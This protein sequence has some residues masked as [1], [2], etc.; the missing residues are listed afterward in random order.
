VPEP[1][2][3]RP[4]VFLDR[5][6]TIAEEVGYLNHLSR[7]RLFP[8]VAAAVCRLNEANL[9]LVVVTNQS[10]V[11]R[12]YFPE[13]L[14][15]AIHDYMTQQL[16]AGGARIDAIYYCPHT[17]TDNCTCRKPKTGML[18]RA[19]QEHAIDLKR[20]FVVGDRYG[21]L[22]LARNAGARSILVRTG[23]GEGELAWHA[24]KWPLQPDFVAQDLADATNWIL[25][26]IP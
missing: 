6:G 9:P 14:V 25:R 11:G 1:A 17:S 3:L 7:F 21:D 16:A 10:G 20:S 4:A 22:Q 12:G 13:S 5:D 26:Q 24:V 2:A 15:V 23:Y 19:A 8:F 18:D